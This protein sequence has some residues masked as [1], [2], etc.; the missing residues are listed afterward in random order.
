MSTAVEI[1]CQRI[2]ERYFGR[3]CS[4]CGVFILNGEAYAFE[5]HTPNT[6]WHN[7]CKL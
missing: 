1:V 5:I 2:A 3:K 4:R 7:E 6:V